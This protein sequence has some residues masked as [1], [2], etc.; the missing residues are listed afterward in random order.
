MRDPSGATHRAE[1]T[2]GALLVRPDRTASGIYTLTTGGE[3]GVRFAVNLLDGVESNI[4][5]QSLPV[6]PAPTAGG[7]G[8]SFTYQ[9]ELWPFL[10]GLA[11]LTLA[12]EGSSTGGARPRGGWSGRLRASDRWALASRVVAL[13]AARPG[14]SPS[15]S[16]RAGWI[17]RT[18]SSCSTCPTA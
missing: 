18:S 13:A 11:M 9:R 2:R 14:G 5:P 15:R 4:R 6:A 3:A 8:D 1:I 12:F 7:V 10:L 16:S 17:G